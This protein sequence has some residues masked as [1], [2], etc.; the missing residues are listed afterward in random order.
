VLTDGTIRWINATGK[1]EYG[2]RGQPVR[3][4]GICLDIT[5]RKQTEFQKEAALEEIRK[6]NE[7]LE[8]KVNERTAELKQKIAELEELNRLFVGRE[9]R[10]A[11]L[12]ER[13]AELEKQKE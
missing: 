9:L 2:E 8:R 7:G 3:M 11:E 4:R 12:K 6:L 13:I 1:G 10:M 5:E